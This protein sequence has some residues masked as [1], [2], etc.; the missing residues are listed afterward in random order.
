MKQRPPATAPRFGSIAVGETLPL[1]EAARRMGW[2]RRAM[3]DVQRAGLRT[4]VIGRIKYT[5]GQW[6]REFV[7]TMAERQAADQAAAGDDAE[8]GAG[9]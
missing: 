3:A 7:E 4:V 6:V 8:E 5:T 1:Q 2:Q 9:K